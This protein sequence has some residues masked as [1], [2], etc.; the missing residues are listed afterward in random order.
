MADPK[1]GVLGPG[2]GLEPAPDL[3]PPLGQGLLQAIQQSRL[4][5]LA[6]PKQGGR[7]PPAVENRALVADKFHRGVI[8]LPD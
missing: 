4:A 1:T 8:M 6:R 5:P 2:S 3:G 7:K